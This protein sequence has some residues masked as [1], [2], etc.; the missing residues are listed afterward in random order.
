[1][2]ALTEDACQAIEGILGQTSDGA[3]L[4]I[5]PDVDADGAGRLQL[6]VVESPADG[7]QVIDSD[8]GP[9]FVEAS[10]TPLLDDKVLDA[11]VTD[12]AVQFEILAQS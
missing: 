1:M 3:G 9:V 2:L 4:R 7:D 10:A 8:G 6:S 5:A 11:T 12:Q